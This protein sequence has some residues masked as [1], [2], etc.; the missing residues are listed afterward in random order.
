M[1]H[2]ETWA[3]ESAACE[4]SDW[5]RWIAKVEKIIGHS[6]DGDEDADG[7]SLDG[8]YLLWQQGLDPAAAAKSTAADQ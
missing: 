7:Y 6:A 3:F 4:P 2:L 5:E 8:F 1:N